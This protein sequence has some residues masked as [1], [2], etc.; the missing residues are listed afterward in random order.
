MQLTLHKDA[1]PRLRHTVTALSLGPG[2][3]QVTMFGGCPKW[4][5]GKSEF[6][7]QQLAKTTVLVF[8]QGTAAG[9]T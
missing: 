4:K 6:V 1:Q 9:S 3:T 2:Q 7:Q 5:W 8:A